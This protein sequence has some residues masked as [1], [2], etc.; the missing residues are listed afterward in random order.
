MPKSNKAVLAAVI[1]LASVAD[2]RAALAA[3]AA[4]LDAQEQTIKTKTENEIKAL[5]DDLPVRMSAI[6]GREVNAG[7]AVSSLRKHIEGRSLFSPTSGGDNAS[8]GNRLTP[9]QHNEVRQ[10]MLDRAIALKQN[11][12][13]AM[14][15]SGIAAKMGVGSQT[16]SNRAPSVAEIE[17]GV[18]A[19]ETP[20]P[21]AS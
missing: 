1:T 2:R 11:K 6:L 7:E 8:K 12:A 19:V 18:L 17:A 9:E 15:I 13:P 5:F 10:L 3:Q 21:A 20:A 4:E 14:T 16:I